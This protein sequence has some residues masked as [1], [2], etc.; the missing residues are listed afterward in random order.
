MFVLIYLYTYR[1]K[2]YKHIFFLKF[3]HFLLIIFPLFFVIKDKDDMTLYIFI[4]EKFHTHFIYSQNYKFYCIFHIAHASTLSLYI[5]EIVTLNLL[6]S[7]YLNK[8]TK[9]NK[10]LS[11]C[12]CCNNNDDCF[13]FLTWFIFNCAPVYLLHKHTRLM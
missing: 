9:T 5:F 8:H 2:T 12:C 6:S 4:K 11:S 10:T 1:K 13:H 7:S 3:S